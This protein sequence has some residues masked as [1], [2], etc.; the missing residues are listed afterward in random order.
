MRSASATAGSLIVTILPTRANVPSSRGLT[1]GAATLAAGVA[2]ALL[3]DAGGAGGAVA[4]AGAQPRAT[5][6]MTSMA[7]SRQYRT[8]RTFPPQSWSSAFAAPS[9]YER[10]ADQRRSNPG[11]GILRPQPD[12]V[13]P[14]HENT[15]SD[16]TRTRCDPLLIV[17]GKPGHRRASDREAQHRNGT[18]RPPRRLPQGRRLDALGATAVGPSCDSAGRYMSR[19]ARPQCR[20]RR[21]TGR[22]LRADLPALRWRRQRSRWP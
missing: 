4:V 10:S 11:N 9:C 13:D 14:K 2:G 5:A 20:A 8:T 21:L 6:T 7:G 3:D 16:S 1:V 17:A 22:G 18:R 19:L 15:R 12:L